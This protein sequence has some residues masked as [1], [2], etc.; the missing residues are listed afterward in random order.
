MHRTKTVHIAKTCCSNIR[1][2]DLI[3]MMASQIMVLESVL[4][5][6]IAPCFRVLFPVFERS[7]CRQFLSAW[8]TEYKLA[9]LSHLFGF[10]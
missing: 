4:S 2:G 5:V 7:D 8:P 10:L 6:K 9:K 1:A 3:T